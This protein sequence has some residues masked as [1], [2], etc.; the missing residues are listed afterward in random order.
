MSIIVKKSKYD[1][2][3]AALT[4]D[5]ISSLRRIAVVHNGWQVG[6]QA[7]DPKSAYYKLD[8]KTHPTSLSVN[9][10]VSRM[11]S[12]LTNGGHLWSETKYDAW[13][14]YY[15]RRSYITTHKDPSA[16]RG[17]RHK[18]INAVV[19]SPTLGGDFCLVDRTNIKEESI[20]VDVGNAM[21]FYPSETD[22]RV[23]VIYG[24]SRLIL[25]VGVLEKKQ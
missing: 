8:I 2:V 6:R 16:K 14:I 17:Y 21:I 22:H 19:T 5:E 13:L 11:Y 15:P 1:L 9:S 23:S 20:H 4:D 12:L 7:E 10:A 25:S 24:G 18:R 3:H